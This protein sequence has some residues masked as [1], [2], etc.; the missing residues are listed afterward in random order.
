MYV[1][2]LCVCILCMCVF[3]LYVS[4]FTETYVSRIVGLLCLYTRSL[5]IRTLC[6]GTHMLPPDTLL[7]YRFWNQEGRER[8]RVFQNSLSLCLSLPSPPLQPP[9]RVIRGVSREGSAVTKAIWDQKFTII[10]GERAFRCF[11]RFV[12]VLAWLWLPLDS[13]SFWALR[14]PVYSEFVCICLKTCAFFLSLV[15]TAFIT[16]L[17]WLWLPLVMGCVCVCVVQFSGL[18]ARLC[19][20]IFNFPF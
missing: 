7:M 12:T 11:V 3:I 17:A 5:L 9:T 10:S 6:I 15:F 19:I 16:V 2:V 1:S 14:T 18:L 13:F 8:E 20:R 4:A